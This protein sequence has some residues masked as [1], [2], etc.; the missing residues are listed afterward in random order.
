MRARL[1]ALSITSLAAAACAGSCAGSSNGGDDQPPPPPPP[2]TPSTR[3]YVS[4]QGNDSADGSEATPFRTIGKALTTNRDEIVVG[5]GTYTEPELTVAR[6][7]DIVGDDSGG[8]ILDGHL[9]IASG[10]V[11]V[12]RL[13]VLGGVAINIADGVRVASATIAHGLKDDT[14]DIGSS[15]VTLENLSVVCGVETCVQVTTS[16]ASI[17]NLSM[18]STMQSKRGLRVESASVA[19][20]GVRSSTMNAAQV[21]AG[22]GSTLVLRDAVLTD[23]EGSG[24][25]AIGGANVLADNLRVSGQR[26]FSV[27]SQEANV[28]VRGS[29]L[30]RADQITVGVQG[31]EL[32]IF[33]TI[34]HG[35]AEGA[36]NIGARGDNDPTVRLMR[37]EVRHGAWPG[38]LQ[39]RGRLY[40]EGT[41]FTGD[42]AAPA[43][44]ET[45]DA[46][47][48][49]GMDTQLVVRGATFTT[50][51][52]AGILLR[53]H[54]SATVTAT[55]TGPRTTGV[56][57][58]VARVNPIVISGRIEDC[59]R[60]S[61][62]ATFD[63]ELITVQDL[64]VSGCTEAGVLAGA[65]STLDVRRVRAIDNPGFAFAAFGGSIVRLS[66]STARGSQW[67]TFATCADGAR[68]EDEGGNQLEG[69][70][71]DCP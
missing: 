4:L 5:P 25:V 64:L 41:R 69:A 31:G 59:A 27:L 34:V 48:S 50:P 3:A 40:V 60:E 16:T 11:S 51:A 65:D 18:T 28:V 67:A 47:A 39:S 15:V 26:R 7:V 10:D 14:V 42:P 66:G 71:T 36:F 32:S 52:G 57:V 22:G 19:A 8:A 49:A 33:D 63:A 23:S 29:E 37:G 38:V 46:I 70:T 68:V 1:L 17:R 9:L 62:V 2:P 44:V 58:D 56:V 6:S 61:G 13:N 12:E 55:I 53:Q 20:S 24:L 45:A 30:S 54:V 43:Q 21:Q 35:S